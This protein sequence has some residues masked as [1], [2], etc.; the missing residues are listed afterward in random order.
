ME[1]NIKNKRKE[2]IE[3]KSEESQIRK[4]QKIKMGM[5]VMKIVGEK[6]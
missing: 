4:K 2:N 6:I 3:S 5:K 1:I